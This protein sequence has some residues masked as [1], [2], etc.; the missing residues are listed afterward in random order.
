MIILKLGEMPVKYRVGDYS[1]KSANRKTNL[2]GKMRVV[3]TLIFITILIGSILFGLANRYLIDHVEVKLD[4]ELTDNSDITKTDEDDAVF[5]EWNYKDD[6][7]EINIEEVTEGSGSDQVTYFVA[8]VVVEDTAHLA[9]AFAQN[10]V[11]TNIVQ[12]TS[13]IAEANKAIFAINGDYY[14][15][16]KD[17]VVIRNGELYRDNPVREGFALYENGMLSSF[18]EN[19][20]SSNDLLAAGAVQSFSFGPV[21]IKDG[22][23]IEDFSG[24]E[25]DTNVGNHSI[26]GSQPRTGFGIISKNHYV[27]IVVDGRSKTYSRGLTLEEF[28]KVFANYGCSQAYNLDGGGSST[29]YFNG[30]VVN[31]PL[32]KDK[33]REVSDII[34]VK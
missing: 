30:R 9:T 10:K 26:Q 33:E 23:T 18:N 13:E 25:V 31:N 7:I 22:V 19:T 20:I 6:D 16:R 3:I 27:F 34:Y 12:K 8:D 32:G 21:L 2:K 1:K 11:G 28:A 24:F 17:G 14:G 4:N 15:F 5:D 29:M